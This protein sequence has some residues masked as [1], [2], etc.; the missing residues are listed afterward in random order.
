MEIIKITQ[1]EEGKNYFGIN[2]AL[3]TICNYSCSYCHPD[4]H[5]G[6]IKPPSLRHILQ[7]INTVFDYCKK[8]EIKPYF[9]FGGGEVTYL[10]WF[11][12]V[13]MEI[14]KR[15]GLV[16]IISNASSPLYWWRKNI[17][18]LHSVSLSFHCE[19]IK[20]QKHFIEV[21]KIISASASTRL[22][23]NIMMLPDRFSEC[24]MFAKQLRGE[25]NCGI[26]LQ[27]LYQGFG[28]GSISGRF[29][30]TKRQE[31]IMVNFSG[32][33]TIK[34]IPEPR[35]FLDVVNSDNSHVRKTCFELL[36]N[37]QT[38]FS[39]WHCHAGLENIIVTFEGDI[40]RAW[41]MQDALIGRLYD[42]KLKLPKEPTLCH[43]K[44]CQCGPDIC[45]SK[46]R[47]AQHDT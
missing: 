24:L 1:P 4:L 20:K 46:Y 2:W 17:S 10:A 11:S 29:K 3:T 31:S 19:Q 33:Q 40:Y 42:E 18:M 7:F 9:E 45:S 25:V 35:G 44:I 15:N 36:I 13:L 47:D 28:G 34:N 30:Y 5:N 12:T 23:V 26:S 39:G 16:S 32:N 14:H 43:T 8:R 41:C 6:K 37:Q 27:P 21:A 22:Q 38:N